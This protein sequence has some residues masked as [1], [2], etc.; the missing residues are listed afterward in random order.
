VHVPNSADR[1]CTL[2]Q[3]LCTKIVRIS[4]FSEIE[5]SRKKVK[6]EEEDDDSLVSAVLVEINSSLNEEDENIVQDE[7]EKICSDD[8]ISSRFENYDTVFDMNR[9][10]GRAV[11]EQFI[12]KP[13]PKYSTDYYYNFTVL[14]RYGNVSKVGLSN[15]IF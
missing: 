2:L 8:E 3:N 1:R 14:V 10:P 7:D 4:R 5:N 11:D 13:N 12:S 15:L 9:F 6:I